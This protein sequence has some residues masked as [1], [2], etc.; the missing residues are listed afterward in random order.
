MEPK[1]VAE[2]VVPALK[3]HGVVHAS[4]FGSFARGDQN[5]D[6]DVDLLVAFE[7]GRSLLDLVALKLDLE[8][9][10]GRAVD[11]VTRNALDPGVRDRVLQ[12]GVP[13]L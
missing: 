3:R 8:Q 6:S 10:L 13:I 1:I 5:E 9:A 12:E 7:L 2:K 11:V 4:L